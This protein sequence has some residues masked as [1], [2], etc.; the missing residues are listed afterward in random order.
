[1]CKCICVCAQT[2]QCGN[3]NNKHVVYTCVHGPREYNIAQ[4]VDA[5]FGEPSVRSVRYTPLDDPT[6][7]SV[8]YATGRKDTAPASPSAPAAT[9]DLRRAELF[10]NNRR[11]Q[12]PSDNVFVCSELYRQARAVFD[13]CT[14][15]MCMKRG[16]AVV[17]L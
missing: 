12:Q 17:L 5:F 2:A 14:W 7:V 11:S 16:T 1:M 3:N 8:E 6:R 15:S 13:F 10:I 4:Q 9:V